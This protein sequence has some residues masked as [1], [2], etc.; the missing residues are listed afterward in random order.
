MEFQDL[1]RKRASVRR[2]SD[3]KP[4]IKNIIR[5]I[6]T[7]NLAPSPG[8]LALLKYVIV[9]NKQKIEKIAEACQQDFIAQ[10][11]ILIVICSEQKNVTT[12]Y[13]ARGRKYLKQHAGAVIQNLLLELTNLGLASCW[14]GAFSDISIKRALNIPDEIEIEAILPIGYQLKTDRIIQRKK[15]LLENRIFFE[16]WKNK[17]RKP[18]AGIQ[19]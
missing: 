14:V 17:Y 13:E 7:A 19:D 6:D 9:E 4:D 15:P 12:A 16:T 10:S 3:K 18:F 8:N 1:V 11:S 2:Y 5:C